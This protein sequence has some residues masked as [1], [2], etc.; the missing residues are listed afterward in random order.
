MTFY[1]SNI[2]CIHSFNPDMSD[3]VLDSRRF[4]NKQNKVLAWSSNLLGKRQVSNN[5]KIMGL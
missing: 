3:T 5:Y 4:K 1:I 2:K